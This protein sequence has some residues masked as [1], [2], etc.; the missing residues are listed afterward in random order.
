[1][2]AGPVVGREL[3]GGPTDG[4]SNVSFS[5]TS[6]SLLVSSWD[7]YVRLYDAD[8]NVLKGKYRHRGPVLDCAFQDEGAAFSGGLDKVVKRFD[9]VRGVED[10]LGAHDLP[11]RCVE[12]SQATGQV[13]SGSW[14]KTVRTWDPRA[15]PGGQ[16]A[17]GLYQV[18]D[19]VYSMS[20]V[21]H[22]LVVAC[23]GRHV[24]LFDLR[25]MGQ[26][27]QT[28][29]SSLKYQTRCVRCYPN[30]TGYALSSI[31][32]RVAMEYF[33]TSEAWQSKKYA[34]KCHRQT[35]DGKDI[36]YPVNAIAYHPVHGTFATGGSDG[37]VNIWDGDNKKR[38]Y[39]YTQYPTGVS[40]LSFSPDG[41][42]LA[43][44]ASYNYEDGNKDHPHDAVFIRSVQDAEVKPKA[45]PPVL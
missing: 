29:E 35:Q 37:F 19:R 39:Q 15:P 13:V 34:F 9:F 10:N 7:S 16:R 30:G 27:E 38:L 43:V 5:T 42:L 24:V 14:D 25:N 18:P 41:R 3:P 22:R 40:S 6:N 26:P 8:L 33:D 28:R 32:G 45:K 20:L 4:I 11:V 31:E 17:V 12:Y 36:I 23:A 21:G 44:A 1:M 2:Q